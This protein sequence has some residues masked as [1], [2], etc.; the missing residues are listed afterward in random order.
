MEIYKQITAII[1]IRNKNQNKRRSNVNRII[2][3]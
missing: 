3:S 1:N 2:K